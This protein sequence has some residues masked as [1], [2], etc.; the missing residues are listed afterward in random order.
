MQKIKSFLYLDE[1]QMYS[2]SSQIF[3]GVTE[4][5]IDYQG[6]STGEEES[7]SGPFASGRVMANILASETKTEERKY[8]HDYSYTLFEDH[9]QESNNILTIDNENID[10]SLMSVDNYGFV[11]VK[12]K[13]AFNDI[14]IIKS[15]MGQF[16]EMGEALT[17]LINFDEI[18]K[19]KEEL[20]ELSNST[21]DRNTKATLRQ[22]MKTLSNL[23]GLA[24]QQGLYQEPLLLEKLN[25]V[26]DYGFRDQFEVRMSVGDYIFT[27]NLKREYLRED[28]HLMIRKF[29]RFPE[30]EFVICG[31]IAQGPTESPELDDSNIS[32]EADSHDIANFKSV[33]FAMIEALSMVE[34][35]FIGK[36]ENEIVI[37]PIAVY[38]EI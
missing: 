31:V 30:S 23:E 21:R 38:R 27:A 3:E 16:N 37:D 36:S 1:Y 34:S 25:F 15:T 10:E 29:S 8:L 32:D 26:L 4:Y 14:N 9:L 6:T 22:R 13:I 35:A 19:V 12:A 28:E 17:Y 20:E 18:R 2:I 5:M 33:I 11:K 7:Q 24:K